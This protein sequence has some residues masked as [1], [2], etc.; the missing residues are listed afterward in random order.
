VRAIVTAE[1]SVPQWLNEAIDQRCPG[2]LEG[3]SH[4]A[5]LDSLW[6][7]LFTWI[8][9]HVF[10]AARAGAWIEA[11]HYYA[12][13]DPRSE[14]VWNHWTKTGD[15]WRAYRPKTY[16][17]FDEW[18]S[19]AM[20]NRSADSGTRCDHSPDNRAASAQPHDRF[21]SLVAQYIEW[22]AFAFWARLAVERGPALP[23][24][25]AAAVEQRSPGFLAHI[26]RQRSDEV[27]YSTWFWK[28][29]LVWVENYA[30]S[31]E[32]AASQLSRIRDSARTHLRGERIAQYWAHCSSRWRKNPPVVYPAFDDWLRDADAFVTT[33]GE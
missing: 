27:E 7:D 26:R 5:D 10:T 14:Q 1:R 31:G 6:L 24:D 25:V 23:D 3:R 13:R 9:E 20:Q 28:N 22:E 33:L 17:T 4:A 11:L 18:H 29:L 2:F 16:P 32:M 15:A 30:F 19:D 8:D 21:F 12:G